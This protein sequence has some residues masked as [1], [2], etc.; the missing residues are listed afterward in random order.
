MKILEGTHCKDCRIFIDEIEDSALELIQGILDSP[1]F[2]DAKIRIMPDTHAGKGIVIG[3]TAPLHRFV[4]PDHVGVDI[5]CTIDSW[6]TNIKAAD[7]DLVRFERDI[8]KLVMFGMEIHE[9]SQVDAREFCRFV[10]H[11]MDSWRSTWPEMIQDVQFDEKYVT[12]FCRRVGQDEKTF[13]K[14]LGTVGGGNHFIEVGAEPTDGMLVYTIHCGSRNLGQKIAK[15]HSK[16]AADPTSRREFSAAK[17]ALVDEYKKTGR[18]TEIDAALKD[19][20]ANYTSSNPEGYLCDEQMSDYLT[21]MAIGVAYALYNHEVISRLIIEALRRQQPKAKVKDMVR[22]VH[23]YVDFSDHVIRKGAVRS[24]EGE[25]LVIPFNMRDGL[26]I[27]RGKSNPDW[28]CSA[29]HG[30]GRVMSRAAAKKNLSVDDF[31]SQMEG[32]VSTSVGA[33]TIDEA[34]GAYKDTDLVMSLI[35]DT[36]EIE[37]LIRPLI[38]LKD[39]N[40]AEME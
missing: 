21:D 17:K 19:L 28:N 18:R 13:W 32:I 7:V 40:T 29:P 15:Y 11:K 1:A 36:C 39:K 30:A 10:Q 16:R 9:K 4:N 5:G 3:F 20:T 38:N 34:P 26:A 12:A 22:S 37:Y 25:R 24:Y 14:S 8:R 31:R 35:G 2:E 33:G 6:F 27:C 23:N